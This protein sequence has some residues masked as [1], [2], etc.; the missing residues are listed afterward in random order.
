MTKQEPDKSSFMGVSS[1]ASGTAVKG[2]FI[3]CGY[4]SGGQ[5][6]QICDGQLYHGPAADG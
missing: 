3:L 1:S 5:E 2:R 4:P 6:R